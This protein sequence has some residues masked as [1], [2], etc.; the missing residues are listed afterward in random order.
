MAR[1]KKCGALFIPP[2][3]LNPYTKLPLRVEYCKICE[4]KLIDKMFEFRLKPVYINRRPTR[5]P[6]RED[7]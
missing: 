3:K 1:C 5:K 2:L 6:R 4:K 7:E